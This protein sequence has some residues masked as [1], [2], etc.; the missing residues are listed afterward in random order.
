MIGTSATY[1]ILRPR[2]A[3]LHDSYRGGERYRTPSATSLSS[4]QWKWSSPNEDGTITWHDATSCSYL[5]P[6]PAEPD[7]SFT[8]RRQLA[9]Y[10]NLVAPIVDAYAE[11][12]TGTV[13]RELGDLDKYADDVDLR[14]STWEEFAEEAARWHGL[15]GF[16]ATIVDSPRENTAPSHA[17]ET[18]RPYCVFVPPASWAWIDV[19]Q[20]GGLTEFAYVDQPFVSDLVAN[21]R[22]EEK[23]CVRLFRRTAQGIAWEVREGT[24]LTGSPLDSQREKLSQVVTDEAGREMKGLL[25]A[26][27]DE[28]PVVLGF[29]KRDTASRYPHGYSIV[30]D[31]ADIARLIYNALSWANE[32]HRSAGFPFL[33]IPQPNTQGAMDPQTA[34]ALGPTRAFSHGSNGPPQWIAPSPDSTRELRDHVVFLFALALRTA[35][36]EVASDQSAQVQSGEALRIKSRD[37]ESRAKRFASNQQRWEIKVLSLMAKFAGIVGYE[38]KVQYAKRF[39]LPD[40]SEDLTNALR[41]LK[42]IP[43]EIGVEA[44]LAVIRRIFDA[45]LS[46][47]DEE[48]NTWVAEIRQLLT[49]DMQDFTEART[50]AQSARAQKM[51]VIAAQLAERRKM[52]DPTPEVTNAAAD[53]GA[54][55]PRPAS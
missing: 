52:K 16:G 27:I 15:Y 54:T 51:E 19:D 22:R 40:P 6:H 1:D 3:F 7:T 53:T 11:A 32:I 47:S 48:L 44:K 20:Y 25:P 30:E 31:A 55:A 49:G 17:A 41:C 33:S 2:M 50:L 8:G 46:A 28:I 42:E 24:V 38:P 5:V 37:F 21:A 12:I 35:G 36:L 23:I 13:A 29:Y 14:G 9:A 4:S 43:I 18:A 45:A 26:A 39:T 10:I 34:V